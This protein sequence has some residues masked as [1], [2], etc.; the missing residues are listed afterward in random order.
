MNCAQDIIAYMLASTGGGAQDGEHQAVRQAVI[1]GVREVMQCRGWLWH[2][3]TSGFVTTQVRT[4]AWVTQGSSD[5]TV[6]NASSFVPGRLVEIAGSA[7]R[8]PTKILRVNGNVITLDSVATE[9]LAA[10]QAMPQVF[11][12]LPPDVRDIDALTTNTV[13]TLHQYI[14]PAEWQRLEI[15]TRG[16]GEPYYYTIMR[17]DL[18]PDRWQVR[19]VGVP[20]EQLTVTYTYRRTPKPIKYMGYERI[21]RQGTV[22]LA[23]VNGILTVTGSGT[24]FPQDCAGAFIRFGSDGDEAEPAGSLRPFV[25]ERRVEKWVSATS[26]L[27]SGTSVYNRP[28]PDNS[29]PAS[30]ALDG[31]VVSSTPMPLESIDGN[32]SGPYTTTLYSSIYTPMP[33]GTKY[34]ITDEIDASPQMYTAILSACEMWYARIAGKPSDAPMAIFNRDLRIAMETD[35]VSPLSGQAKNMMWPTPRSMGWHSDLRADI[36]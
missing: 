27:V 22:A 8:T 21:T 28:G 9:S 2:V 4:T 35:A 20:T 17:S 30:T 3:R 29:A 12:D 6:A 36:L 19:F 24:A 31:G 13:G 15:H 10:V 26:L 7:F 18:N 16:A 14:S 33:A 1:N 23:S 25:M 32:D 34:A 5:I 11:F